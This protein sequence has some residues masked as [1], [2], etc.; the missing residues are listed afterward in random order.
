MPTRSMMLLLVLAITGCQQAPQRYAM[1]IG[2]KPQKLQEYRAL[3]AN[4]WQGVLEQIDRSHMRNFSIWHIEQAPGEHLLFG[5]FEYDGKDFD[6]DMK[7][8]GDSQI[9]QQWWKLTDP[10]QVPIA[11][12]RPGQQWVMMQE[13]FY[14]DKS[15]P[16]A[17][18]MPP[19][20]AV[21]IG[22]AK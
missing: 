12:A 20:K 5:Y 7:A 15:R 8:M 18:L 4:P 17:A 6:A 10:C 14:R 21:D 22:D 13:F 16:G 2:L 9:T 11:A 1:V 3:H 19:P